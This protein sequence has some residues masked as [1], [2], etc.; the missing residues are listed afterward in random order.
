MRQEIIISN[1]I[2]TYDKDISLTVNNSITNNMQMLTLKT[3]AQK[4]VYYDQYCMVKSEFKRE[5]T[6]PLHVLTNNSSMSAIVRYLKDQLKLRYVDI[7]KM[8]GRD[9]RTIWSIY[10]KNH[11]THATIIDNKLSI[12]ISIFSSRKL[13]TLESIVFYLKNTLDLSHLEISRLLGKNYRTIWTVYKRAL[14]KIGHED[15]E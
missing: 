14:K 8:L 6:I 11:Q 15:Y 7:A 2:S 13:S 5:I 1:G 4:T 3:A 12:P 10:K 9:Q